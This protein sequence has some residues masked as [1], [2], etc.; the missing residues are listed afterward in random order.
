MSRGQQNQLFKTSTADAATAKAGVASGL[1]DYKGR[2]DGYYGSDPYK[3]GGEFETD[4]NNILAAGADVK[5]KA[6]ENELSRS[7]NRSG[8]NTAGYAGNVVA[9]TR[10][11]VLDQNKEQSESDAKRLEDETRF[12]QFGIGASSL[13]VTANQQMYSSATGTASSAAKEPGLWDT[14]FNDA[15]K[16]ASVGGEIAA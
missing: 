5:G 2:L 3:K 16:G 1:Q 6:V 12:Q 15:V 7:G 10:Q 14:L 9:A 13:P 11:A 8:Q 4:Q